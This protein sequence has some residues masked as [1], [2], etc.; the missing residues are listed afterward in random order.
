MN[1]KGGTRCKLE[2]SPVAA[3]TASSPVLVGQCWNLVLTLDHVA[4][5]VTN[6]RLTGSGALF[7]I[8]MLGFGFILQKNGF[9]VF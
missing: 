7:L 4:A 5:P 8:W 3:Q 2:V 9:F 1:R 6:S